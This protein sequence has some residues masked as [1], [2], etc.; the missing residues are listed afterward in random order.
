MATLIGRLVDGGGG[1]FSAGRILDGLTVDLEIGKELGELVGVD[2]YVRL[3]E[4]VNGKRK[5]MSKRV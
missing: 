1:A 3:G 2:L 5:G 4:G